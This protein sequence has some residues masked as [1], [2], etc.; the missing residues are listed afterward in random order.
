MRGDWFS[1]P[2]LSRHFVEQVPAAR[3]QGRLGEASA[4]AG[5]RRMR[6]WLA[7][8]HA[9]LGPASGLRALCDVG[10]APLFACLGYRLRDVTVVGSDLSSL[11]TMLA[12][13]LEGSHGVT[14]RIVIVPWQTRLDHTWRTA[15]GAVRD[16]A[17]RRGSEPARWAFCFNGRHL[18]LVDVDR[19]YARR[20]LEFDLRETLN[21][22]DRSRL[23]WAFA[24]PAAFAVRAGTRPPLVSEI[25]AACDA[26]GVGVREAL[27]GGVREALE[28]LCEEL[29]RAARRESRP[30]RHGGTGTGAGTRLRAIAGNG[31]GRDRDSGPFDGGHVTDAIDASGAP[32][33]GRCRFAGTH[34]AV[35]RASSCCSPRLARSCRCGI[36]SIATATPSAPS[37]VRPSVRRRADCG[38]RFRRSRGSRTRDA[39]RMA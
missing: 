13:T 20:F 31:I 9:M 7:A 24:R 3:S 14:L 35:S 27:Q 39:R 22:S 26:H 21:D 16:P 38:K 30:A 6:R 10:A 37:I 5:H 15:I 36:R 23:L 11:T 29:A 1:G 25:V 19:P 34:A 28:L 32:D 8:A 33:A 18:R 17:G 2:L 4:D 12:G